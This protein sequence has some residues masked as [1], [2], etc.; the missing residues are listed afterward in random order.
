[1]K[2]HN[3]IFLLIIL[4]VLFVP[5]AYI[6]VIFLILKELINKNYSTIKYLKNNKYLLLIL[7]SCILS[8]AFSKYRLISSFFGMMIFACILTFS[9]VSVNSGGI[10]I[11][12]ILT[13]VYITALIT[14]I[15]GAVQMLNPMYIMPEKWVDA[16]EFNLKKRMFSTF[17]NPNVFGF[18]INIIIL[19]L[20]V[21]FDGIKNKRL[22]A[23]EKITFVSSIVCLFFTFSRTSWISLVLSLLC[24]GILLDKKYIRYAAL[25]FICIFAADILLGINRADITKLPDDGSFSYRIELWKTSLKII[26]DNLI[27]GIGFGTFFKYTSV[28]SGK[29]VKYIEHCHNIYLQIFMESGII[30]FIAFFTAAVSI[31]KRTLREYFFN[32]KDKIGIL[33]ILITVMALIHGA[34]DSVSLTPQIMIILSCFAGLVMSKYNV[35]SKTL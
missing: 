31:F 33:V 5:F 8:V 10:D 3:S 16:N 9:Y 4:S 21:S 14:Y 34:V 27:T 17:F 11:Q 1:M 29:I 35:R 30:G 25:I 7:T 18:Y 15:V 13:I 20:C 22:C 23:I 19:I 12:R 32:K 24:I 26:K 6:Y 28:Y 2:D